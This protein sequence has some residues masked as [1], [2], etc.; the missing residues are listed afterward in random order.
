[1]ARTLE[2]VKLY[3]NGKCPSCEGYG[4]QMVTVY[5]GNVRKNVSYHMQTCVACNGSGMPDKEIWGE[6]GIMECED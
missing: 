1:M 4:E 5:D 2:E 6:M 3:E